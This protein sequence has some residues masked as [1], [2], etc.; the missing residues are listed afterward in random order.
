MFKFAPDGE[1]LLT[2][3]VGQAIMGVAVDAEGGV[4]GI[5]SNRAY[6]Y[7]TNGRELCRTAALPSLYTY[8]DMTGIQL[9]TITLRT[10]RWSIKVD[11]GTQDVI[12]DQIDWNGALPEGAMIDGRVRTAPT[13]EALTGAAWSNRSMESPMQIPGPNLETGY[14]NRNRWME[15]EVRLSRQ[16]EAVLPALNAFVFTG[17]AH[18]NIHSITNSPRRIVGGCLR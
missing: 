13:R 6:R 9:L 10:G 2:I 16:D 17:S 8:S 3:P 11:G 18:E 5:G 4:F 7:D 1:L 12:W 15:V 14:T